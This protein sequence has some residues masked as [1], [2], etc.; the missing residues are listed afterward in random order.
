MEQAATLAQYDDDPDATA[1]LL[2]GA[3]R[4]RFEHVAKHL[5]DTADERALVRTV[6]D[7]YLAQGI[8][9]T[10]NRPD[11]SSDVTEL[12]RL[13]DEDGN[14]VTD[15]EQVDAPTG[16]RTCGPTSTNAGPTPTATR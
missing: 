6:V 9:A 7:G 15:I 2:D 14:A 11:Y 3:A 8:A 1:R 10:G 4:G 5:A 16:W 13:V 12:H